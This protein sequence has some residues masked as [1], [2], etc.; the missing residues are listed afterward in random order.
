MDDSS[1]PP[2]RRQVELVLVMEKVRFLLSPTHTSPKYRLVGD[3]K[4]VATTPIPVQVTFAQSAPVSIVQ[5]HGP[6]E[7]GVKQIVTVRD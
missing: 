7:G 6:E 4:H 1:T 3:T 2:L 5:L